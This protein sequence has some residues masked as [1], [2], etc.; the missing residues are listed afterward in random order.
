MGAVLL[1]GVVVGAAVLGANTLTSQAESVI[2]PSSA[3]TVM[4]TGGETAP[5]KPGWRWET[6]ADVQLQVPETWA[7]SLWAGPPDC[8]ED[9]WVPEATVF[10]PGGIRGL[11]LKICATPKAARQVA[12]SVVFDGER[13]GVVQLAGGWFARPGSSAISW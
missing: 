13:P 12:P 6:Y 1:A 9:D 2:T 5:A 7:Q 4:G 8:T 3:A 11:A 10:R